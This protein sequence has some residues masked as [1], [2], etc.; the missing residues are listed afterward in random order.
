MAPGPG[1][2]PRAPQDAPQRAAA[3]AAGHG[4][5]RLLAALAAVGI[6]ADRRPQ[7][8]SVEEWLALAEALGP[9]PPTGS[10]PAARL[11]RSGGPPRAPAAP[12]RAPRGQGQPALAVTGRRADGYHELASVFLR[13]GLS[14]RA[15][16]R[17]RR[18]DGDRATDRLLIEGD[19]DCPVEGN[20]VLRAA[21][22][23]R[24]AG[25]TG[26][27]SSGRCRSGWPDD[28][29]APF[30]CASASRWAAGSAAAAATRR[31]R[32]AGGRGPGASSATLSGWRL[33]AGLGADVPFFVGGH[34]AALVT[35][36]GERIA[37]AAAPRGDPGA[38]ARHAA[39]RLA[40][41]DVFAAFD[42]LPPRS[43]VRGRRDRRAGASLR[44]V[45]TVPAGGLAPELRDA[46]DLWPAAVAWCPGW[47][48]CAR[49]SNAPAVGRS[50][51]PARGRRSSLSILLWPTRGRRA[52]QPSRRGLP[53]SRRSAACRRHHR[54]ATRR[55][56]TH[57][58]AA[59]RHR[60]RPGAIG[61]YSQAID[62]D[63]FVF[64]AGQLGLDPATGDLVGRHRRADRA[65][66]AEPGR[67][68]GRRRPGLRE[69]SSRR[70]ASWSTSGTSRRST[71]STPASSRS[72]RRPAPRS[73]WRRCRRAPAWRSRRSRCAVRQLTL[74]RV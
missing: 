6:A 51:S 49:G 53:R 11:P 71:R 61:P 30:G 63:G 26:R 14:D 57:E 44:R 5:A 42:R 10:R 28:P 43:V 50:C 18:R 58:Q 56:G 16:A 9:L 55:G 12:V 24:R 32:S 8:L 45:S 40:T 20:L 29:R 37:A 2:L 65:R 46:N 13:I 72:R 60:R 35:G 39:V 38:A 70:P 27:A 4:R 41:A 19:P 74:P 23:A 25:P 52:R 21:A 15:D 22:R 36:I 47:P 3:A 7:T 69:T 1:R 73:R 68:A 67:R 31:R 64:C 62:A 17:R 34:P 59:H 33:G 66:A 54:P 48:R